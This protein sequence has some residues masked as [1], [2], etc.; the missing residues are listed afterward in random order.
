ML[1]NFKPP[2]STDLIVS[3]GDI[4]NSVFGVGRSVMDE[5]HCSKTMLEDR[6]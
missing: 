1:V 2:V 4:L 5:A 3:S 6:A